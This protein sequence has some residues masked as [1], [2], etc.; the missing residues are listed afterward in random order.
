MTNAEDFYKSAV[1]GYIEFVGLLI[2]AAVDDPD[3][4][5]GELNYLKAHRDFSKQ[6]LELIEEGDN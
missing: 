2:G 3:T 4:T 1:E 5:P 6:L